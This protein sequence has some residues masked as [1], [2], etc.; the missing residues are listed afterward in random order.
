MSPLRCV[1]Q[2]EL[3]RGNRSLKSLGVRSLWH[4]LAVILYWAYY[5]LNQVIRWLVVCHFKTT[6]YTYTAPSTYLNSALSTLS[7]DHWQL[8]YI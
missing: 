3:I 7:V 6:T 5:W 2:Y 8:V 1:Q 4:C